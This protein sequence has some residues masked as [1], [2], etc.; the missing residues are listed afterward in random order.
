MKMNLIAIKDKMNS[1][2]LS[3]KYDN[4]I[5]IATGLALFLI[6]SFLIGILPFFHN[7]RITCTIV[8]MIVGGV[9]C[10]FEPYVGVLFVI[11]FYY[12][13]AS[14]IKYVSGIGTV[15]PIFYCSV[16][17]AAFWI[18]NMMVKREYRWVNTGQVYIILGM[19]ITMILSTFNAAVSPEVSWEHNVKFFKILL[20]FVVFT[21]LT[22]SIKRVNLSYWTIA[23]GCGLLSTLAVRYLV[24]VGRRVEFTTG[25]LA[26]SNALAYMLVVILP[27]FFYKIFSRNK[28]EKLMAIILFPMTFFGII[29]TMSRGGFIGLVGVMVLL[30]IRSK[31]KI[32][33]L[34]L[35]GCIISAG[36]RFAPPSF[37]ERM[38]TIKTYQQEGSAISRMMYWKAGIAMW[39]DHPLNG[40]GQDNFILVVPQYVPPLKDRHQIYHTAHNT[41]ITLL[42]EGGIFLL[43][44]Y[45]LLLL[46]NFKDLRVIR[47][48]SPPEIDGVQIHNLT[49]AIEIGL[50]GGI[51]NSIF[52]TRS[53]FEPF[54]WIT[55]L[56]MTLKDIIIKRKRMTL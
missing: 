46:C 2:L 55:G 19:T 20:F 8:L 11:F 49:Y 39:R 14:H 54:F 15:R 53:D 37:K 6:A 33:S 10:F 40:V 51:I 1:F 38:E 47:R 26:G 48:K 9:I 56:I 29:A 23:L 31:Q 3:V 28:L 34:I 30:A 13:I 50:I 4:E 36:I 5:R 7:I 18:L 16:F 45:L 22:D 32:K 44:F 24:L 12:L 21:N 35:V 25:S 17:L 41:Y 52:I 43:L 27:F 42:S